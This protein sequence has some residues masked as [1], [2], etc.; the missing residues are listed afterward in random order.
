LS[1]GRYQ[2]HNKAAHNLHTVVLNGFDR[3]NQV[4][5]GI[6]IFTAL[7]QT[8]FIGGFYAYEDAAKFR[9][10]PSNPSTFIVGDVDRDLGKQAKGVFPFFGES[11]K[12]GKN[13]FFEFLFIAYEIII[14]DEKRPSPAATIDQIQF[15][16]DLLKRIWY[17]EH[18]RP[19][20]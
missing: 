5:A 8:G 13:F 2:T 14:H 1:G 17:E 9:L 11:I 19:E 18:G 6:L 7:G 4:P 3:R 10:L 12:T 15:P 16:G 20:K